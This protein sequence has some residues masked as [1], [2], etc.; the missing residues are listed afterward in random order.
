M[1]RW[2]S[3]GHVAEPTPDIIYYGM[4]FRGRVG[5]PLGAGGVLELDKECEAEDAERQ[6]RVSIADGFFQPR[7]SRARVMEFQRLPISP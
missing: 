2:A 4:R 1:A 5:Q 6:E 7:V 3:L